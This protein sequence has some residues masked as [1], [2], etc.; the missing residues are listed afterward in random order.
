MTTTKLN[1]HI[2]NV[3]TSTRGKILFS[4]PDVV[5]ALDEDPDELPSN[6]LRAYIDTQ[7]FKDMIDRFKP[8]DPRIQEFKDWLTSIEETPK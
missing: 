3:R 4:L 6:L 5:E 7:G 2:I 1:G 8:F